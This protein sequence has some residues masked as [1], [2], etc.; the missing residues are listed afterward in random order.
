MVILTGIQLAY[1]QS[2]PPPV[3][4]YWQ[5]VQETLEAVR[6]A[7]K[8]PPDQREPILTNAADRLKAVSSVTLPDGQIVPVDN[9]ALIAGLRVNSPDLEK[10]E[11]RLDALVE[12]HQSWQQQQPKPDAFDKLAQVLARPE[13]QSLPQRQPTWLEEWWEK[14]I[15]WLDEFLTRLMFSRGAES[16]GLDWI[17]LIIGALVLA[18]VAFFF[19]RNV[20]AHLVREAALAQDAAELNG[21][22]ASAAVKQAQ[23]LAAGAD[24]R[25]AV[26]YLY[27]AAL[28]TLDERGVLRYDKTLTNRQVLRHARQSGDADLAQTMSPV[29]DTFDSVWY[30]FAEVSDE[31]YQAYNE[32]I[33]QVTQAKPKAK[34]ET[35]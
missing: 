5:L 31:S 24:Y 12:T 18:G 7:R 27:L 15:R 34:R 35:E 23:S 32:Q 4:E 6:Q 9:T 11:L 26:R 21:L 14:A 28:L 25:Q 3:K 19:W 2:T 30:G 17:V 1:A 29:V 10:L 8:L 22:S 16:L 20:R 33:K 13:F